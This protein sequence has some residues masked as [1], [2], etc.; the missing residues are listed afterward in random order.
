M[1]AKKWNK[2]SSKLEKTV[3]RRVSLHWKEVLHS[4]LL[5]EMI[6]AIV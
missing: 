5:G 2:N 3:W 6:F 1:L 4:T